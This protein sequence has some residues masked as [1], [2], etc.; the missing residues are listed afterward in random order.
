M[1]QQGSDNMAI[2]GNCRFTKE[3][4]PPWKSKNYFNYYDCIILYYILLFLYIYIYYSVLYYTN[5]TVILVCW[6][7]SEN[8]DCQFV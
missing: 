3:K 6:L 4:K 2:Q 8:D 7:W 1:S 5:E